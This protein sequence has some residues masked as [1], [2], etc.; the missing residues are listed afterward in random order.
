[1]KQDTTQYCLRLDDQ[2]EDAMTQIAN[3]QDDKG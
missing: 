2:L 1:M 3:S